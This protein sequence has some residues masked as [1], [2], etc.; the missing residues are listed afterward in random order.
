MDRRIFMISLFFLFSCSNKKIEYDANG[1][2]I[3]EYELTDNN[4]YRLWKE[5]YNNGNLKT[6]YNYKKGVELDSAIIYNT[7]GEI[8]RI[9]KLL[10]NDTIFSKEF[11]DGILE[12]EGKYINRKNTIGKWKFY[13]KNGK[14]DKI[15]EY[16]NLCGKPYTNQSW[17]FDGQGDTIKK[18]GNYYEIKYFPKRIKKNNKVLFEITYKPIIYIN[19]EVMFC[20]DTENKAIRDFCN[21]HELKLIEAYKSSEVLKINITFESSGKKNLR[22]YI[23]EFFTKKPT[24][25]DSITHGERFVYFDIPIK[26]D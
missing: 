21:I 12:S 2:K 19:S 7:N 4:I 11:I 22:G 9:E 6:I 23:K 8:Q 17:Y 5:Y 1:N 16:I 24:K 14:I 10:Q 18:Y 15:V 25:Q 20:F 26:V 3:K 13:K